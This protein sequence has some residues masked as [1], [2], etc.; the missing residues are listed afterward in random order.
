MW[1]VTGDV[2]AVE[3]DL[4]ILYSLLVMMY[5]QQSGCLRLSWRMLRLRWQR[6]GLLFLV[7]DLDCIDRVDGLLPLSI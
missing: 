4:S 2:E 6:I 1:Y 5:Q 3:R 7:D